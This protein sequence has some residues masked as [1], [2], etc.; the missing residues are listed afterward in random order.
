AAVFDDT[1]QVLERHRP[2]LVARRLRLLRRKVHFGD[3]ELRDAIVLLEGPGDLLIGARLIG[4]TGNVAPVGV[5]QQGRRLDTHDLALVLVRP[6]LI[7]AAM[8]ELTPS[9]PVA[10]GVHTEEPQLDLRRR[11][12]GFPEALGGRV[13]RDRVVRREIAHVGVTVRRSNASACSSVIH[14]GR[15]PCP[16]VEMWFS[17]T[18]S[19]YSHASER[20]IARIM[21]ISPAW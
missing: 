11:R 5:D 8:H 18:S 17:S 6:A 4:E 7:L 19:P 13:D 9:S 15:T 21:L 2:A 12:Q 20:S 10:L 14:G 16:A 1:L 3:G